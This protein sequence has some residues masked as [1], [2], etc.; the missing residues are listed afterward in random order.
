MY[1]SCSSGVC[2][3]WV[4]VIRLFAPPMWIL[5][6]EAFSIWSFAFVEDVGFT[7]SCCF[8][9]GFTCVENGCDFA[10]GTACFW[11]KLLAFLC[12]VVC[13]LGVFVIPSLRVFLLWRLNR[14]PRLAILISKS[15]PEFI[16]KVAFM[17]LVQISNSDFFVFLRL[18]FWSV[19]INNSQ[20][21]LDDDVKTSWKY[22]IVRSFFVLL[23]DVNNNV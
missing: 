10:F 23:W 19:C 5:I 8:A 12:G 21:L 3:S 7:S 22:V 1:S 4:T 16:K 14:P 15:W 17:R 13:S 18:P 9:W 11:G 6:F 20:W 2:L